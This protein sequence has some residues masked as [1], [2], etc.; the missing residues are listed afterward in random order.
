[1]PD[2]DLTRESS[3]ESSNRLRRQRDLGNEH[4]HASTRVQR[5]LNGGQIDLGLAAP[6]D[7][8][9][10]NR[11]APIGVDGRCNHLG[12]E[13]LG[14]GQSRRSD[15][16]SRLKRSQSR[17][18]AQ[19]AHPLQR[20]DVGGSRA[21]RRP[22]LR[23][24]Y[25]ARLKQSQQSQSSALGGGAAKRGRSRARLLGLDHQANQVTLADGHRC[26]SDP[27]L[28]KTGSAQHPRS[29]GD[30]KRTID[31]PQE[32]F[33]RPRG[34]AHRPV[35]GDAPKL[36]A[37]QLKNQSRWLPRSGGDH[38]PECGGLA[39]GSGRRSRWQEENHA[40][41][42]RRQVAVGNPDSQVELA[43]REQR[44]RIEHPLDRPRLRNLRLASHLKDDSRSPL[45]PPGH[46]NGHAPSQRHALRR[47]I[48]EAAPLRAAVEDGDFGVALGHLIFYCSCRC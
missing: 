16:L 31:Q 1:M 19:I 40:A 29:F 25:L 10:E 41:R 45:R 33:R 15:R 13:L 34:F 27:L 22:R 32:Q 4:D 36:P 21:A 43:L 12:S 24:V 20:V 11:L 7:A 3:L 35:V 18:P 2:R 14:V 9:D 38:C 42:N 37:C 47:R 30:G 17:N 23:F 46:H 44:L 6:G 26:R 28:Q 48:G 39:S 8:V 5:T